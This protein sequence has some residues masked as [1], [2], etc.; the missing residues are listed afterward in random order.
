MSLPIDEALPRLLAALESHRNAV[1]EAPPGAGKS[2]GVPLALLAASW[3]K[4]NRILMLEPRRLAARAVA[5]RMATLLGEPVGQTVGYRTRLESKVSTRTR[6]EVVTEGILTR[7]LQNDP[8]LEGVG[9]V[10]FDEFHERSVHADLGLALCLEVQDTLREDLRLLVMSATLDGESVARLLGSAPRITSAGKLFAV[11]THYQSAAPQRTAGFHD[12]A[13]P[14]ARMVLRSLETET[15]D[16]L[17]FLPGQGEIRRTE[18]LLLDAGL[19]A[20]TRIMPLY[21]E[22]GPAEQDAALRP[23]APG[24]RKVVLSTN[25]AETSL[26]IEGIRIV[27]D[28][29]WVRRSRFDPS[30]G[31]N[32]LE[33][34]RISRASADQRRGR[35][36]RLESGICYRLWTESE[37]A[38]LA[39][40]TP[41]EILETDL[42]P[43]A[44]EIAQWGTP[45]AASL[46]WLDAPPAASFSRARDLLRELE[47]IDAQGRLTPHGREMG[48]LGTHPRLAHL[49][50]KS[51]ELRVPRLGAELAALL[52]ERDLLRGRESA[53]DVD[54]RLRIDALRRPAQRP[55]GVDIDQGA[56]KRI[57]QTADLFMRQLGKSEDKP[58]TVADDMAGVLLAFAYPDRIAQAR[59]GNAGEPSRYLL[60]GGRGAIL[61]DPQ[62]LGRSPYLVVAELDAGDRESLIR[63]AAPLTSQQLETTF[64]PFIRE[65]ERIAWDSRSSAVTASRERWLGALKLEERMLA[66]PD[67]QA[68]RQAMLAG[69]RELGLDALPWTREARALQTRMEFAR[70]ADNRATKAWPAVDEATLAGTLEAWLLPWLDGITRRDHLGRLDLVGILR[71]LLDWPQQQRLDEIAPTHL[72]VPSGSRIPIEYGPD[73]PVL[74]VRLQEV[75]GL[76]E[77]P[78]LGGGA[79]PVTLHLLSPARRPVQVTRDLKSF[80]A[81][82]YAE[83]KKELKG[84]YPKHYWPDNP[85]EAEPTA[86]AK[87]RGR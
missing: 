45:D 55:A 49:L 13:G 71:G 50:L 22:L 11:E 78:R 57:R 10:I 25:L 26:T 59:E 47:A 67:P 1:V 40:Q 64:A 80:W 58:G 4:T 21:G 68:V 86:R 74:S 36:G 5:T 30:S 35:A 65:T 52:G 42:A 32:R 73:G 3:A 61:K 16:V 54:L 39:A 9:I 38:A 72:E 37:H 46:R 75:F 76:T 29:G 2:T 66:Q 19:G 69:L 51:R 12:I 8:E 7:R 17:V 84:R 77:T 14:V 6:I 53:R 20:P 15:G 23:S 24:Q 41:A 44:L 60:S 56:R 70:G 79:V 27:V 81:R 62:I 48:T 18:R 87:P 83:V 43:L 34:V 31:M 85:L 33:T 82:G 28:S 63:L